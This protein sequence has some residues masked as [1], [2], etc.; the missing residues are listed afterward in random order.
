MSRKITYADGTDHPELIAM[1]VNCTEP[2]CD[3]LCDRY[4]DKYRE[5]YEL[6]VRQV[7]KKA[8]DTHEPRMHYVRRVYEAFGQTHTM[9]EWARITGLSYQT[10]YSRIDRGMEIEQALSLTPH[11]IGV[12]LYAHGGREM[13]RLEWCRELNI[14]RSRFYDNLAR[15]MTVGQALGLEG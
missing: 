14:P 10:I 9:A 7:I 4:C 5:L 3:G 12:K 1:C 13:S 15:G 6:P 8:E 2:E 11:T